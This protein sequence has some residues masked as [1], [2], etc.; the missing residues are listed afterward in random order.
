MNSAEKHGVT[1]LHGFLGCPAD[2]D[3]VRSRLACESIAL[4]IQ[5]QD[6]WDATVA[7]IAQRL[8]D[9]STLV[10]YSMGGR[11]AM[12]IA[13]QFPA[14]VRNLV[15]VAADPGVPNQERSARREHDHNVADRIRRIDSAEG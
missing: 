12:G 15:V 7:S 3:I 1:F 14:K 13:V 5:P 10:G 4:K 8:P 2:W 11:L 6:H 9:Q